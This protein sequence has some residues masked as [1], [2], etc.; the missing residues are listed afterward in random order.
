M[1]HK[2]LCNEQLYKK[3]FDMYAK[4]LKRF[5]VIKF[6]DGTA[7]DDVLQETFL[8]LWKN[9]AKVTFAKVKS[10]LFTLANN[11]FLDIKKH[12]KVVRNY[13]KAYV[14]RNKTESPEFLMIE[15]E[16]LERVE[17]AIENLPPKQREVFILIKIEKKKY[18]EVS[19]ML[20]L[21][22]KAIEKRMRNAMINFKQNVDAP[23]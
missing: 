18:K 10:Y 20:G 1:D 17:K 13:Q 7:A 11:A 14:E 12:E 21:S 9:C 8:K 6:N 2:D 15:Q 22:V 23:I 16:F 5:L 19:E 4:D 3:A